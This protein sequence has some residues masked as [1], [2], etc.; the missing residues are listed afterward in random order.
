MRVLITGV[1]P[2]LDGS[3]QGIAWMELGLAE[4][5]NAVRNATHLLQRLPDQSE[6]ILPAGTSILNAYDQSEEA[7]LILER[8]SRNHAAF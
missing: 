6:R 7:L 4:Q 8:R 3:L 2:W 5:P 1:K